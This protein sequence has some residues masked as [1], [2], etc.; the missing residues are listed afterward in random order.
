M[1]AG[2]LVAGIAIAVVGAGLVV[3]LFY[4][5]P[6]PT[7]VRTSSVSITDLG[8][9]STRSWLITENT[10]SSGTLT[11]TWLASARA[12]VSLWTTTPCS[13]GAGACPGT[14][15]VTWNSNLNGTWHYNG[16]VSSTYLLSVTNLAS[17]AQSFGGT[18]TESYQVATPSQA[19]PAWALIAIGGFVLLAIGAI[20]I[21][22]GMFLAPGVFRPPQGDPESVDPDSLEF[23]G[24]TD[25][26]RE[27]QDPD[28]F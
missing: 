25:R 14:A 28:P 7:D 6:V 17:T 12:T 22:L 13:V 24:P 3:S 15:I 11:L 20:A 23:S 2:L 18:L 10:A 27:T 26:S 16:P 19:V 9:G 4:L 21:F 8:A 5:P 1:R